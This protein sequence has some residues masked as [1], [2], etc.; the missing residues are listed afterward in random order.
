[1]PSFSNP[2][3]RDPVARDQASHAD[4]SDAGTPDERLALSVGEAASM[5]GISRTRCQGAR[6]TPGEPEVQKT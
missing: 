6:G 3:H 4:D 2:R 1:M 5:L